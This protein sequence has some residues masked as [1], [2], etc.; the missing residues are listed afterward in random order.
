MPENLEPAL[1]EKKAVLEAFIAEELAPWDA[2]AKGADAAQARAL[3]GRVS[4]RSAELGSFRRGPC[5]R[6]ALSFAESHPLGSSMQR[7]V[8][9]ET[10]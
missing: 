8:W 10:K 3:R 7:R 6:S 9:D 2:E 5:C 1:L 4:Q